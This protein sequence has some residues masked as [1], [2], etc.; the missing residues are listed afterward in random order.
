M[1]IRFLR[2]AEESWDSKMPKG[3]KQQTTGASAEEE[4]ARARIA[5]ENNRKIDEA[6]V[7]R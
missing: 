3:K 1:A 5:V 7:C 6:Q 2:M 4:E